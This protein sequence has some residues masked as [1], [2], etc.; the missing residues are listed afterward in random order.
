MSTV[1]YYKPGPWVSWRGNPN[2]RTLDGQIN[3]AVH[4]YVPPS[5]D[6]CHNAKPLCGNGAFNLYWTDV[7]ASVTCP[8]CLKRISA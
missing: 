2:G 8:E 7:K 3:E 1:P 4:S 6:G 5:R